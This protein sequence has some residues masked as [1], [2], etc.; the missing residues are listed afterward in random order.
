VIAM[1]DW[2]L[3]IPGDDLVSATL[4]TSNESNMCS[5]SLSTYASTIIQRALVM[6]LVD[7]DGTSTTMI[8]SSSVG[9]T[10]H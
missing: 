9:N 3:T 6:W 2:C 5:L 8:T 1:R 7:Y 10:H 4:A